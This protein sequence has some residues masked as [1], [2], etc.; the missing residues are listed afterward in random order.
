MNK[1]IDYYYSLISPWTYLGGPRFG[2]IAAETGAAINFKPVDLGR[3]FPVSG[4]LPLAKRASQ[5]QAYRLLELKR[6]RDFLIMPLNPEPRHFPADERLAARMVIAAR[7]AGGGEGRLSNA[8][9][10]AVW[11][12]ERDIA[13]AD[14]LRTIADEN[15]MDG[16]ALLAAAEAKPVAEEY[17]ANTAEAIDRGVFG[18]PSYVYRDELFW[19]QDRLDFLERAL[20]KH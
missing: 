18:A 17:A 15:E 3:I 9:L 19:G 6:W 12:E 11:A 1:V 8:I 7:R 2:R 4:G 20:K 10:R 16:A 14:T 13:D 5:R